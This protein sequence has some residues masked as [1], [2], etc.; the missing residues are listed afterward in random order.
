MIIDF[1]KTS[2]KA[3]VLN[4]SEVARQCDVS[5]QMVV[6]V[7]R[8]VYPCMHT[9]LAKKVLDKLRELGVLVEQEDVDK[10]A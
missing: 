4:L 1:V 9:A 5:R 7:S 2:E 3:K 8:G 6:E 10:A